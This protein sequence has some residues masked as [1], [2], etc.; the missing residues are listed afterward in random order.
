MDTPELLRAVESAR[1]RQQFRKIAPESS[2]VGFSEEYFARVAELAGSDPKECER[3]AS[4]W[5][6]MVDRADDPALI[7]RA[8]AVAERMRGEWLEA[9]K[10]F[11]RS[12][13]LA[14]NELDRRRFQI[15]AIDSLARGGAIEEAIRK[16]KRLFRQMTAARDELGAVRVA[17]NLGNAF[18]WSDRNRAARQRYAWA[19]SHAEKGSL[20]EAI[21]E[22][23]LSTAMI[24]AGSVAEAVSHARTAVGLLRS[25]GAD[26]YASQ[27]EINLAHAQMLTGSPDQALSLLLQL[28]DQLKDSPVDSARIE[29]FLGECFYRLNLWTEAEDAFS[30]ALAMPVL[31]GMPANQADC[32][33]GGALAAKAQNKESLARQRFRR[34]A[35]AYRELGNLTWHGFAR[36]QA[37][38]GPTELDHIRAE[39][40]ESAF[41]RA[42]ADVAMAE[43]IGAGFRKAV[44]SSTAYPE[45]RWRVHAAMATRA[46][47]PLPHY[48]RMVREIVAS[49]LMLQSS[50]ASLRFLADKEEVL[51]RYLEALLSDP[52]ESRV[53]EALETVTQLRS[54]ALIDELL[55]SGRSG[56]SDED[57]T[58]LR[59]MR[60]G[61]NGSNGSGGAQRVSL[62][63][64]QG[65]RR[66]G[67]KWAELDRSLVRTRSHDLSAK[68]AAVFVCGA[69][70]LYR[71]DEAARART[72][73][74]R[75]PELLKLAQWLEFEI[76]GGM[77]DCSSDW[78][79]LSGYL[80]KAKLK[81]GS[82]RGPIAPDGPFWSLPWTL[83]ADEEPVLC[84]NPSFALR[85]PAL[86]S[87]S[88]IVLWH[89]RSRDLP[90]VA[91]EV[92]AFLGRF[93]GAVVADSAAKVRESLQGDPIDL[94]HVACH[95]RR[96]EE[97]PMFSW[98]EFE[99]GPVYAAE[100]ARS[101]TQI[102]SAV[103]NACDTGRINT[104]N[105]FEPDGFVRAV[106]SRGSTATIAALW[107]VDDQSAAEFVETLYHQLEFSSPFL[108]AVAEARRSCTKRHPYYRASW[109]VFGGY[110]E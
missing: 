41:V 67:R 105:R 89:A 20:E 97:N 87:S 25:L 18:T 96:N 76:L 53:R 24:Y 43:R 78:D 104:K 48:R 81:I 72:I 66:L 79:W 80:Q 74:M 36:I 60:E 19:L 75:L 108:K 1:H 31:R 23:G 61:L 82:I 101:S 85:E 35:Q 64:I 68:E 34:A 47:N 17:L 39:V 32:W 9:A 6:W 50:T 63:Y 2:P 46:K 10:S 42:H 51:A 92:D 12:G 65:G 38:A 93:P 7:W 45:L 91:R 11:L 70:G 83:L 30:A 26:A 90:S 55:S 59:A 99:D 62:S 56:L 106:L 95:S 37:G 13:R 102:R 52:T 58:S 29:Q 109:A 73:Q 16:G 4:R 57:W 69:E 33:L 21:A 14:L 103:L 107:P 54:A 100:I 86:D 22:L 49:R 8:K 84:L 88:R 5:D 44:I 40:A 15:G 94:L 71:I 28:R 98:L 77:T 3:L 27:A 110:A